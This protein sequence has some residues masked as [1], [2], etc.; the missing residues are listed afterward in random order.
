MLDTKDFLQTLSD[1]WSAKFPDDAGRIARGLAVA[2]A[3]KVAP[4]TC[5]SWRVVGSEGA[6]YLVEVKCGFPSC[7]CPDFKRRNGVRCKHIWAAAM[8]TRLASELVPAL[9]AP[10][11]EPK[12]RRR[13][14]DRSLNALCSKLHRDNARAVSQLDSTF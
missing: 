3:G 4:R 5:E 1:K 13:P 2:L 10:T 12:P 11:P 7:T 14:L 9:P 8:M 6:Q